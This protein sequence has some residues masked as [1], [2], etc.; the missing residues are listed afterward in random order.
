MWHANRSQLRGWTLYANRMKTKEY[1]QRAVVIVPLI[2]FGSLL[3][4]DNAAIGMPCK[5]EGFSFL[6]EIYM[7]NTHPISNWPPK[8]RTTQI[9]PEFLAFQAVNQLSS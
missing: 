5:T 1:K 2:I 8:V 6:S 9:I 4:S 3:M 7:T